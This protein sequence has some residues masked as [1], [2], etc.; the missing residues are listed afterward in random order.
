MVFGEARKRRL[1]LAGARV[2]FVLLLAGLVFAALPAGSAV[3]DTTVGQTGTPLGFTG[4]GDG[5]EL[6]SPGAQIPAGGGTITSFQTQSGP[7]PFLKGAYDFQ[8]LRPQGSNAYLASLG[9]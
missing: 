5:F 9:R 7:C 2:R 1:S 8:V 4:F 6:V 3:A